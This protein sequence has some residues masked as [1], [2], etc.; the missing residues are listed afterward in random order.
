L[1]KESA[2]VDCHCVKEWTL[3][4]T[5]LID[6]SISDQ[7]ILKPNTNNIHSRNEKDNR[8]NNELNDLNYLGNRDVLVL[9]YDRLCNLLKALALA[10]DKNNFTYDQTILF[11]LQFMYAHVDHPNQSI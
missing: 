3:L 9:G 2:V 4:V 8:N 6:I 1:W 7:E 5:L 10:T 11:L